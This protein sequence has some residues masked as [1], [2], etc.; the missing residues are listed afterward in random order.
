[1]NGFNREDN[2]SC[3]ERTIGREYPLRLHSLGFAERVK[4]DHFIY[5]RDGMVEIIN[6]QPIGGKAKAYQVKQ[7]RGIITQYGL[8]PA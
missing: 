6:L 4:G 3:A 7:V 1:M 5:T 8:G 2:A